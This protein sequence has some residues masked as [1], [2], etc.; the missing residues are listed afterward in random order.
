MRKKYRWM[1][2]MITVLMLLL[3]ACG[4]D[5]GNENSEQPSEAETNQTEE[6][7]ETETTADAEQTN[8]PENYAAVVYVTINPELALYLDEEGKVLAAECL[9]DDAAEMLSEISLDNL[10]VE[11]AMKTVINTAVDQGFLTEDKTVHVDVKESEGATVSSEE[12]LK[13]VEVAVTEQLAEKEVEAD[14]ALAIDGEEYIPEPEAEP[15][16]VC[17]GTG[18][19]PECGGGTYACKRCD[20]TLWEKCG[21]CN[22]SGTISCH[23]CHGSG[24]S[25]SQDGTVYDEACPHCGGKGTMTCDL[26]GGSGGKNCSICNGTGHMGSDCIVCHGDKNCTACGGTGKK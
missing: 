14:I 25:T 4:T 20:G 8:I 18:V 23:G 24:K 6:M 5:N 15:C 16:E 22:G 9:N 26:C 19:C 2:A 21:V 1:V 10:T 12:L 11:E 7:P 13:T 3:C 17:G